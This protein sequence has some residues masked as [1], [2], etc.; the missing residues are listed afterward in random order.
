MNNV[1]VKGMLYNWITLEKVQAMF[2]IGISDTNEVGELPKLCIKADTV[3]MIIPLKYIK[4]EI[5][6]YEMQK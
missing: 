1:R 5:R 3:A 2:E 4:E 6:K